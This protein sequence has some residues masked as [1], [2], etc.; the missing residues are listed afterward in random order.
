[1]NFSELLK[2]RECECGRIH[3][4]DVKEVIVEE[5]AMNHIYSLAS[6]YKNA[7][8]VADKNTYEVCG[9]KVAEL[10]REKAVD[11]LV[12]EDDLLI[13]NE[14]AVEKLKKKI[15]DSTDVIIGVG[16]GVIQDLCKYVSF[17]CNLPYF[18]VAT[19]PSMDGYASAGAAL[20]VKNMKVTYH[21]HVP[22]VIIADIDIMKEAPIEMIQSGYGDILG[23]LS[24]LNDWKLAAAVNNEYFCPYVYELTME[25]V[26]SIKEDGELLLKRDAGAIKRL[27]EALIGVGIAMA[28]VGNSRPA[29]G[30]EHHMAHFF[31]I[32]GILNGEP[33][34]MHGTDVAYAAWYTS[35]MREKIRKIDIPEQAQQFEYDDWKRKIHAIYGTA[36]EGVIE[37]Q[38]KAGVYRTDKTALYQEKWNEICRI[39]SDA[40]T[41]LE[42]EKYL[43][44][45]GLDIGRFEELYGKEKIENAKWFAKDLKDRYSVLWLYFFLFYKNE[46]PG[47]ANK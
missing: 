14:I 46:K 42:I 4:C 22:Q 39:L 25:M 21:A 3:T 11:T 38:E 40:P 47:G 23:K 12:Y 2:G 43:K 24:C 31:E 16:S 7:V 30:S 6:E 8:V 9:S 1:M 10:L 33:Y 37:L 18:I 35:Q 5:K 28:Y 36:A 19:A 32:V 26:Y 17:V 15:T 13:P 29:S 27:S 44:S 20:I 34:F 41:A 45:I